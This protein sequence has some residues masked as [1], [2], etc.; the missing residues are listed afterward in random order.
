MDLLI[1]IEHPNITLELN[2]KKENIDREE[3]TDENDMSTKLLAAI[4]KLCS[5]NKIEIQQIDKV[6]VESDH[7]SFTSTR[8]AKAVSKTVGCCLDA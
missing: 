8:I 5:R 3:W 6:K 2:E 7:E 4:D 1:K